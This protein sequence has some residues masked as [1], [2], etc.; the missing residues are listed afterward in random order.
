MQ[1]VNRGRAT[2]GLVNHA[3]AFRQPK[4]CSELFFAGIGIQIEIQSDFFESNWHI[5]GNAERAAKIEISFRS[6]GRIAQ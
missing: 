6:N 2:E 3:I 1:N 5:F 4:Q